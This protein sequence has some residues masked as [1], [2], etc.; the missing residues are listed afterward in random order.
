M[1]CRNLSSSA[2]TTWSAGVIL[3]SVD[4]VLALASLALS[5][6]RSRA[7]LTVY[8]LIILINN[9]VLIL[10]FLVPSTLGVTGEV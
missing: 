1:N 8:R 5:R 7:R 4:V 10:L 9:V 3:S 2:A 6:L